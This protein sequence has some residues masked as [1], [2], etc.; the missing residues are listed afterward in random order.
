MV[1]PRDGLFVS[2]ALPPFFG[3]LPKSPGHLPWQPGPAEHLG[4][5]YGRTMWPGIQPLGREPD[6]GPGEEQGRN[7]V[8]TT[9]SLPFSLSPHPWD[10]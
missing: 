4:Q 3:I 10:C 8:Q 5:P 1:H 9:G 2:L 7:W 6:R